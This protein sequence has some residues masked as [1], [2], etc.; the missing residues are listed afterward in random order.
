MAHAIWSRVCIYRLF[1]VPYPD[2]ALSALVPL[3]HCLLK[4][5]PTHALIQK[6]LTQQSHIRSNCFQILESPVS[7]LLNSNLGIR[8]FSGTKI[9]ARI[10]TSLF[11]GFWNNS[12]KLFLLLV[13]LI[14]LWLDKGNPFR[15]K[16]ANAHKLA[17]SLILCFHR[18]G[19][20]VPFPKNKRTK[21]KHSTKQVEIHWNI[22]N[23]WVVW[24]PLGISN[25]DFC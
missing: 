5:W 7:H 10:S 11:S 17:L 22:D 14:L 24:R 9:F 13:I 6:E 21:R 15:F 19:W 20:N 3:H 2:L 8:T 1:G 23:H 12:S 16:L 4:F 25:I 18:N